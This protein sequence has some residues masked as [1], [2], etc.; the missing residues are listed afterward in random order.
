[1]QHYLVIERSLSGYSGKRKETF[2]DLFAE[3]YALLKEHG[4]VMNICITRAYF[5]CSACRLFSQSSI[6]SSHH[7]T[8]LGPI[9]TRLGKSPARI[10]RHN[11][12]RLTGT[13]SST[14]VRRISRRCAGRRAM[15]PWARAAV[16]TGVP[17]TC[18]SRDLLGRTQHLLRLQLSILGL[19]CLCNG[20]P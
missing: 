10:Q 7:P 4:H 2:D 6:S 16:A 9:C 13:R 20:V 11:V 18:R 3:S 17:F 15:S 5:Y 12:V 8:V 1:M 14:S 19:R